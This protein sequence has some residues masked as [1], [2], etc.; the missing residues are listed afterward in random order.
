MI[1]DMGNL[2]NFRIGMISTILGLDPYPIIPIRYR[3][4]LLTHNPPYF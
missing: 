4:F 2:L 1:F 3:P